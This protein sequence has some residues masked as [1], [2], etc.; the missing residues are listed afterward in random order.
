LASGW[1]R[2]MR[3]SLI[4]NLGVVAERDHRISFGCAQ[5]RDVTGE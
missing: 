1:K 5:D 2:S 4:I 3:Q